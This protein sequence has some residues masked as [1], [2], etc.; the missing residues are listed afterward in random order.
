MAGI[1]RTV[2]IT[3][4]ALVTYGGQTFWSKGDVTCT[5]QYKRFGIDTSAWGVIEQRFSDKRI[6]V[7][8]EPSGHF[9]T[10]LAAVLWPYAATAMGASIYGGSDSPLVIHGRDGIKLTVPNAAVTAMPTIR[11]GVDKTLVGP[12]TFTGLL[13]NSADGS[14]EA[15]YFAFT[16]VPFP[17]DSGY[18]VAGIPTMGH[19][20]IWKAAVAPWTSCAVET[21][22]EV[23]FGLRLQEHAVDGLGTIDMRLA[24][25]DVTAKATPVG[26]TAAEIMTALNG[27]TALGAAAVVSDLTIKPDLANGCQVILKKAQLVEAGLR[28]GAASKRIGPCTWLATRGFTTGAPDALFAITLS[29]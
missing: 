14:L 2:I 24:G 29:T 21:G 10:A 15:S 17:A 11:H 19:R 5:P 22:A 9:S 3:G 6:V 7:S 25:M 13:A 4:P 26:P 16:S 20:L 28:Y 23:S 18:V 8:F 12:I 1:N 27:G